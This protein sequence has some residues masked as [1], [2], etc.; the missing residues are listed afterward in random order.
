M[1]PTSSPAY[2]P[3]EI[4]LNC[5]I[6]LLP[7]LS[8]VACCLMGSF[9]LVCLDSMLK[10]FTLWNLLEPSPNSLS[11]DLRVV[12][13]FSP[14]VAHH[15]FWLFGGYLKGALYKLLLNLF[16]NCHLLT[17]LH[18][19]ENWLSF[20]CAV[21]IKCLCRSWP[22]RLK[23]A[24]FCNRYHHVPQHN[25]KAIF[26]N[27]SSL[28]SLLDMQITLEHTQTCCYMRTGWQWQQLKHLLHQLL[29]WRLQVVE[30]YCCTGN[31]N[32]I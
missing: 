29:P 32:L 22:Q 2:L 20:I 12:F 1:L 27:C 8:F 7:R 21:T 28:L 30:Q 26:A 24:I 9:G 17:L 15:L 31:P 3:H 10:N 13:G 5:P 16:W 23:R 14:N 19:L 6:T 25:H 18:H 11:S 4:T